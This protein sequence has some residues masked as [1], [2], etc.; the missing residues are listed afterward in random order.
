MK[1]YLLDTNILIHLVRNSGLAQSLVTD[2]NLTSRENVILLSVVTIG[3]SEAFAKKNNWGSKKIETLKKIVEQFWI[4]DINSDDK[5]LIGAYSQIDAFSQN[6]LS[7]NPLG[8]SPRNMGKNDLWIAATSF[9][10][11]ATLITTDG[12]F[13]HLNQSFID[14]IKYPLN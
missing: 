8:L 3:E 7:D 6:K 9:V 12:D 2:L 4:L 10:S 14:I 11:K 5:T 1:K 13:D